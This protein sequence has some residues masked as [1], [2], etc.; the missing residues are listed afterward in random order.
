MAATAFPSIKESS[1][2]DWKAGFQALQYLPRFFREIQQSSTSLFIVNFFTRLSNSFTP[3]L[4]LWVGKLIIDE[5]ISLVATK[6]TE[7]HQL[8][9]YIGLEIGLVVFSDL[10][11]R[12][13]GLSDGLL[14]DRYSNDSSVK[15][16]K[17]AGELNISHLEDSSF[18]D[19]LERARTQTNSR[20]NLMTNAFSQIQDIIIIGTLIAGL[21]FFEPWLIFMLFLSIIPSFINEIKFS[22]SRYSLARSWTSERRELDYLRYIGANDKTAMEMKLFGLTDYIA[23]RFK[24]L[25]DQYYTANKTLAVLRSIYG[26]LF[27]LLGILSYYGA[28]VLIIYRVLHGVIS[29]GEL[30]FLS[31]SFSRLRNNLQSSFTRFT[32]ISESA[33]YLKDYFDYLDLTIEA[34]KEALLP[35]P[36]SIKQGFEF[37]DV[38]FSYPG[39][40]GEV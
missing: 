23:D 27:N 8:G 11:N 37:K 30:T 22:S 13:D 20:V 38:R 10:L 6:S 12:L 29:L 21:V 36:S 40:A 34:P 17:K 28:Y 35:L 32:R 4:I 3:I 33:L 7:Y 24:R 9:I 25:S 2:T 19:K 39:Q 26:G 16:I 14:G 18:Y 15:I 5:I 31:A 1:K